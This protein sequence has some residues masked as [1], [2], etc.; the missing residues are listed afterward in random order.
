MCKLKWHLQLMFINALASPQQTFRWL[1][2][3]AALRYTMLLLVGKKDV[4]RHTCA[5]FFLS[6][7]S[8]RYCISSERVGEVVCREVSARVMNILLLL[9]QRRHLL[10]FF[11]SAAAE[12][13][14]AQSRTEWIF[15][16][17]SPYF[18][19]I[20]TSLGQQTRLCFRW[21]VSRTN[22][23]RVANGSAPIV[24]PCWTGAE[25]GGLV[26]HS[27]QAALSDPAAPANSASQGEVE[28]QA[29]NAEIM[30]KSSSVSMMV[31]SLERSGTTRIHVW[32]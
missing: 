32:D 23:R 10:S 1:G 4:P 31:S 17:R 11:L 5:Q 28:E 6:V 20:S 22:V 26:G 30:K 18:L 8:H 15:S 29:Q 24:P 16:R 14:M 12:D 9:L 3:A 7:L 13:Q 27:C 2:E 21:H 19:L 25:G